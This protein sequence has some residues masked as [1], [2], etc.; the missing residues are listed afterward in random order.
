MTGTPPIR[1]PA[2]TSFNREVAT[3][4]TNKRSGTEPLLFAVLIISAVLKQLADS[5]NVSAK[6]AE[7]FHDIIIAAV[8]VVDTAD[9]SLPLSDKSR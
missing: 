3:K 6:A 7:L 2:I 5:G 4:I 1:S 8:N 9:L